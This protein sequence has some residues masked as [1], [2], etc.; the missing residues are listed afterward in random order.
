MLDDL[1]EEQYQFV[2]N[3]VSAMNS[4]FDWKMTFNE[5]ILLL[6]LRADIIEEIDKMDNLIPQN[7]IDRSKEEIVEI[8]KS[9]IVN[10]IKIRKERNETLSDRLLHDEDFLSKFLDII[11]LKARQID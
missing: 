8:I 7:S 2:N 6:Q 5:G 4:Q 11:Y 10:L 3:I 1:T 9:N